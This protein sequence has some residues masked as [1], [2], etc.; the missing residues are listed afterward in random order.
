M[1]FPVWG[2]EMGANLLSDLTQAEALQKYWMGLPNALHGFRAV[3]KMRL[4][5]Q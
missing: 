5:P 3:Q 4:K 2:E 1:E